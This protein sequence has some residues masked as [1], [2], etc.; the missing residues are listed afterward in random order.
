[1]PAVHARQLIRDAIVTGLSGLATTED[2]VYSGRTRPLKKGHGP[3]LLVYAR[4]E[5]SSRSTHGVPP[6]LERGCTV[7]I[8]GRVQTPDAPD[9]LLDR[10]A[11]EVEA[12]MA[13]MSNY[14]VRTFLNGLASNLQLQSTEIIAEADSEQHTGGVRLAY[15]VT[16]QTAE[17]LPG[18]TI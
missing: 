2:R 8:E 12:A 3:A 7:Y 9:D 16:Y 4:S 11:A 14:A 5:T 10:I 17:G 13:A 18:E 15:V 6:V 1:M